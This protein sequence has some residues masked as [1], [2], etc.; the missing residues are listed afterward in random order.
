MIKETTMKIKADIYLYDEA[1][2]IGCGYRRCWLTIGYKWVRIEECATG[3]VQKVKRWPIDGRTM[4]RYD[5]IARR[6]PV[7]VR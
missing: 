5:Y 4:Q 1:P 7:E 6:K 2:R 3:H